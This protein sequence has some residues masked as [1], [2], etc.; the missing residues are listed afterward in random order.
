ML[1]LTKEEKLVLIFIAACMI[2]GLGVN[3]YKKEGT[4]KRAD[5]FTKKREYVS[6]AHASE[7]TSHSALKININTGNVEELIKLKGIGM[8]LAERIVEYRKE[9]GLFFFKEDIIKIKGIGKAKF[10]SIKEY[11]VTNE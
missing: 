9:N 5:V 11:I 8:K 3:F 1:N 2:I 6:I 10:N 7:K 4:A